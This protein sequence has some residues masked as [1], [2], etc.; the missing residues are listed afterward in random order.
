MSSSDESDVKNKIEPTCHLSF[1]KKHR[2]QLRSIFADMVTGK[3]SIA[4]GI[5]LETVKKKY[6]E[7][8]K[9]ITERQILSRI[10]TQKRAYDRKKINKQLKE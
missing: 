5:V 10:R 7:L 1:K 8:L 3:Q 4:K 9:N 2:Q 6:P